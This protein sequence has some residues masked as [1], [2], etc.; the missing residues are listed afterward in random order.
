[1]I[2]VDVI[3]PDGRMAQSGLAGAWRVE[4][5]LFPD[6]D[7]WAAGLMDAQRLGHALCLPCCAPPA[8]LREPLFAGI[9]SR[10]TSRPVALQ[11]DF[12]TLAYMRCM[13]SSALW[14]LS[15]QLRNWEIQRGSY[16]RG[17]H[18][19]LFG[20]I[21]SDNREVINAYSTDTASWSPRM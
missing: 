21:V 19:L 2:G 4:L 8:R 16:V 11:P 7:L 1:M 6:E 13:R 3:D 12:N 15:R 10:E 5:D 18:S 17:N 14:C 9:D 20:H